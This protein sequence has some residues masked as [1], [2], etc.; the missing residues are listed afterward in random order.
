M[1][2]WGPKKFRVCLFRHKIK[3]DMFNINKLLTKQTT[4]SALCSCKG[5]ALG[6]GLQGVGPCTWMLDI[7]KISKYI[8]GV[9]VCPPFSQQSLIRST[10]GV[11]LGLQGVQCRL[12]SCLDERF[13]RKFSCSCRN[14]QGTEKVQPRLPLNHLLAE[15]QRIYSSCSTSPTC[16]LETIAPLR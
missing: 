3:L 9:S 2:C 1:Y 16:P 7:L 6:V 5:V 13:S 12:G 10:L 11:L 14:T 15:L 4:S 8:R